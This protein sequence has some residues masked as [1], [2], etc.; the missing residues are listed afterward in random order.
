MV[1]GQTPGD[2]APPPRTPPGHEDTP[3]RL[4]RGLECDRKMDGNAAPPIPPPDWRRHEGKVCALQLRRR[5]FQLHRYGHGAA[6]A[7]A[8]DLQVRW[9]GPAAEIRLSHARAHSD[10]ARL[11]KS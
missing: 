11:Q 3:P 5:L 4:R 9:R 8:A 2:S 6:S 1:E 10:Q 7:D